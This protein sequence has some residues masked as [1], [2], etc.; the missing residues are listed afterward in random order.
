V[1]QVDLLDQPAARLRLA[2]D[3]VERLPLHLVVVD[4]AM[5]GVDVLVRPDGGGVAPDVEEEVQR[6]GSAGTGSP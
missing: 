6:P 5:L 3:R 1:R 4:E 2:R